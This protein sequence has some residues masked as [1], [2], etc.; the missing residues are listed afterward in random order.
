MTSSNK[1]E[2]QVSPQI[3]HGNSL[4]GK[5]RPLTIEERRRRGIPTG[6]ALIV[7]PVPRPVSKPSDKD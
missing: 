1:Q 4:G 5:K 3:K 7:S 6:D 2:R